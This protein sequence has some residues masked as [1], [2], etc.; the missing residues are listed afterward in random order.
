MPISTFVPAPAPEM[1]M[2]KQIPMQM[3]MP[4]G[5]AAPAFIPPTTT[6]TTSP[7]TLSPPPGGPGSSAGAQKGGLP[8]E[9]PGT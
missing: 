2:Q 7:I 6:T 8:L 1:L 5:Y 3:A 9:G 4:M